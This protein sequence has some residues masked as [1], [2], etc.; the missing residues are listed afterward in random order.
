MI[1][2]ILAIIFLQNS[3]PCVSSQAVFWGNSPLAVREYFDALK[4]IVE[5]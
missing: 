5:G 2:R 4:T 3:E 1:A